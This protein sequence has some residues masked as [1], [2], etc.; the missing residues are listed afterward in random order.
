M[1][2]IWTKTLDLLENQINKH[3]FNTWLSPTRFKLYDGKT[4]TIEVPNKFFKS[5]LLE[6]YHKLI[7][8]NLRS[9]TNGH[10]EIEYLI[11]NDS[12]FEV[13]QETPSAKKESPSK[14][15]VQ[16]TFKDHAAANLNPKYTFNKFV[17]GSCNQFA[18]AASKAVA[19]HP[20]LTYNPLFIY[21]GVGLGKTH[22]LHGIGH[23]ILDNF[24][25]LNVLY[26]QSEKFTNE[27]IN[28]IRYDRMDLFRSKYRNIDILL[29]DDIQFIAGK[30]RTEEEFF[31][32]FNSLF[33]T[34]KQIVISSDSSPKEIPTIEERLRSRF[35]WGLIAD[36]QPPELET[37][38]AILFKKAEINNIDLPND[39][40]FFIANNIKSNIRELEGCLIKLIAFSS[41]TG[42]PISLD[43]SKE[44]LKDILNPTENIIYVEN[45]QKVICKYYNIKLSELKSKIR[46]RHISLPRQIAMF[47]ARKL[48]D[49]SLIQ[50]GQYFGGKDHTTVMHACE[51]IEALLETDFELRQNINKQIEMIKR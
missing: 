23:Y 28:S 44:V 25:N 6:N 35:E 45:I 11:S 51:K 39:V 15:P 47:L 20:S 30:E 5:W 31:H 46:S 40:A 18:H 7:L 13:E 4:L 14:P 37:K 36:I 24:K 1:E 43:M 19:E 12:T 33:E 38:V 27:L 22:L 3:S 48:T 10:T 50:I 16:L 2:N 17:V 21:G 9:I 49:K 26:I 32:T 29:I 34:H 42:S 8:E 41:L